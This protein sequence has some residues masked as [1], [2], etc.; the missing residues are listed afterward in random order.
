MYLKKERYWFCDNWSKCG[1]Y[2]EKKKRV[3]HNEVSLASGNRV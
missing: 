3:V 2:M 1:R